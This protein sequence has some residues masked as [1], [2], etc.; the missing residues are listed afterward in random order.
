M[1]ARVPARAR[2]GAIGTQLGTLNHP[3]AR[4]QYSTAV[5][6]VDVTGCR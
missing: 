4:S 3:V 2:F 6:M 1:V 5:E